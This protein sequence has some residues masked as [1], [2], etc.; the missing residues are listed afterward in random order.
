MDVPVPAESPSAV[1]ARARRRSP[2]VACAG[3]E[4][5]RFGLAAVKGVGEG[6]VEVIRLARVAGG[7]F[8]SLVDFCQRVDTR[9]VNR[10]TIEALVKAGAFDGIA[11]VKRSVAPRCSWPSPSHRHGGG[12]SART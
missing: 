7:R 5:I 6:A 1:G 9:K 3:T 11:D 8:L 12:D 2:G 10:K 4:G